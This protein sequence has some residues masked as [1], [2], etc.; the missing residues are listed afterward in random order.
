[1]SGD[2]ASPPLAAEVL[3]QILHEEKREA[4]PTTH[5]SSCACCC[6]DC[7]EADDIPSGG[8]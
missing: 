7:E 8:S 1:M 4:D 6:P 5:D 3:K 2:Q